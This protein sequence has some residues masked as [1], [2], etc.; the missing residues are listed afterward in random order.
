M[1]VPFL[2]AQLLELSGIVSILFTGMAA[3]A[4]VVPNLSEATANNAEVLFRLAAHLAETAIFL[5]LGLSVWSLTGSLNIQFVSWA[6]LAC[7]IGR[8]LNVFPITFLFNASLRT[9]QSVDESISEHDY[10]RAKN[11]GSR[12]QHVEMTEMLTTSDHHPSQQQQDDHHPAVKRQDSD[13][14]GASHV[15]MTPRAERDLRISAKT[16]TMLWFSGL[17]GAVAYACV[18][19]FPDTFGHQREFV[20]TTMLIVLVTVFALGS[21]TEVMIKVLNIDMN[22][23]E[24]KYME[25]WHQ[26]RESAGLILQFEEFVQQHAVRADSLSVQNSQEQDGSGRPPSQRS[27]GTASYHAHVEVTESQHLRN[28]DEMGYPR[29]RKRNS[30]FDYGGGGDC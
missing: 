29:T 27:L 13:V 14:S 18:R 4:Y 8:A 17:R 25:D 23:D 10:T 1:Y 9:R 2:L 22:V 6:L 24:D 30:V 12:H 15:S 16:A 3:R 26:Q 5:E 28:L 19:S 11:R 7:L 21:T 20:M